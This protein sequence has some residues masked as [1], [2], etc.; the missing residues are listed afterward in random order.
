MM[1]DLNWTVHYITMRSRK[2]TGLHGTDEKKVLVLYDH[3]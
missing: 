2:L 1:Y 3:D